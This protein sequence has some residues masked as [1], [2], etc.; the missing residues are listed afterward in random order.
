MTERRRGAVERS[1]TRLAIGPSAL[2]WTGDTLI[3]R[4]DE[5]TVPLPSR[6]RGEVRLRPSALANE[7][8][9]LDAAGRHHWQPIAPCGR[10]EVEFDRP[11]MHWVGNAYLD[12]NAG[13]E[14]LEEA[15]VRWDWS[16]AT[17][18]DGGAAILYDVTRR[19][20]EDLSLALRFD[21]AG[22]VVPFAPPVRSA[23]DRTG[24]RVDRGTRSDAGHPPRLVKTLEDTPFYARS[25][26]QS[27]LMG[28]HVT[29]VHESLS[30][31]RFASRWVQTLLPFR[32]PRT[33]G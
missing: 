18:A 28:Q 7:A 17:L 23:L 1:A 13:T 26:V 19:S 31:D 6:V 29:A 30:L 32:M 20:G 4:I 2:E 12:H 11:Q 9:A 33:L 22:N 3:V 14:P 15:F 10:V 27:R 21:A 25:L 8:Y 24:W 16:R 5:T